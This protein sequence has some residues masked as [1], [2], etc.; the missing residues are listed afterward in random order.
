MILVTGASG[1]V[2]RE[3]SRQLAELGLRARGTDISAAARVV[4]PSGA[5]A[6]IEAGDLLDPAA[7]HRL[8][9]GIETIVH[10]AALQHH[11]GMPRWGRRRF[12]GANVAMT[13]NLV[14]A[15][16]AR[17]VRHVVFISSD[18]VYGMPRGRAMTE[19]DEPRPIGPYGESKLASEEAC[20]S[21]RGRGLIVTILRPRLI[22]GPGRL[23]VLQKLFD[24]VRRGLSVPIF[25]RGDHRYQMVA[26]SD[27]A[28][29]CVLAVQRRCE[30]VFNLGS[31]DPPA[32]RSLMTDLCHRAGSRSHVVSLPKLPSR[33][34]LWMLHGVRMSPLSPEQFRIAD[35]DYVL[36]TTAARRELGWTPRY[37]D[38]EMLWRAY[39]TY[40]QG[41]AEPAGGAGIGRD[42]SHV[43]VEALRR[44]T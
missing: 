42:A 11:S 19:H 23:G 10:T 9:E 3:L 26:V 2:G 4:S 5:A 41:L 8:C 6:P 31:S 44:L 18:M 37:D 39:A 40:V 25:G 29:A 27:V 36:D 34:A 38:A 28:S 15:A 22:I 13:R 16:V 20:L 33:L 43:G 35:V 32:V 1:L 14:Q 24:R 17:G 21:A 7:C 30:G 12:F